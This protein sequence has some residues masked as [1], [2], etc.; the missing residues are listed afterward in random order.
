MAESPSSDS[1]DP[2]ESGARSWR[3]KNL[4]R[5]T[6]TRVMMMWMMMVRRV[7][8]D[9]YEYEHFVYVLVW[10]KSL[11]RGVCLFVMEKYRGVD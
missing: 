7:F 2:L 3:V 6:G 10:R 4:T 1:S 5:R 8:I 11:E 9:D